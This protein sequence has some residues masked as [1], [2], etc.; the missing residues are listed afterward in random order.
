MEPGSKGFGQLWFRNSNR[1][2]DPGLLMGHNLL[3]HDQ[4]VAA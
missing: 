3:L 4:V 2:A 1:S